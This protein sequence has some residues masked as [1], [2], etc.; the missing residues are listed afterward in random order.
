MATHAP[1]TVSGVDPRPTPKAVSRERRRIARGG[2]G[3][4]RRA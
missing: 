1:T 3:E 2:S 4:Y